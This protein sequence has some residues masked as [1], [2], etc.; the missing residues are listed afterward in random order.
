MSYIGNDV[1]RVIWDVRNLCSQYGVSPDVCEQVRHSTW[2]H[3][4]VTPGTFGQLVEEVERQIR[5]ELWDGRG[6]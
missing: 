4:W 1:F 5:L 2:H 3:I 6:P